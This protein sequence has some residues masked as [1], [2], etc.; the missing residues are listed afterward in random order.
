RC[1]VLEDKMLSY[2]E[3]GFFGKSGHEGE[4]V[5]D[6]GYGLVSYIA[7]EYGAQKIP[8]IAHN[9]KKAY[10][11]DM[12]PALKKATGKKGGQLYK[13]WK[14]TLTERYEK[15][16]RPIYQNEREGDLLDEGG[17][18][19]IAPSFSPDGRRIAYLSN[20]GS[21]YSIQ[22]VYIMD[23][24]GEN[25]KFLAGL[26]HSAPRFSPDG[27]K[28]IFSRK[29]MVDRYGSTVNDLYEYDLDS[30]KEKQLTEALRAAEPDYSPDGTNV[31]CVV[32]GDGSH[33][34]V[35][36][37]ADGENRRDVFDPG[38]GTQ[39]YHP[40]FSPDGESIMFG[41]FDGSTRDVAL[42]S[43]DGS[44][45][46]YLLKSPND[47]RDA[48]W[49][50]RGE[51]VIFASD[52]TGIYNIYE[53]DV[54]TGIVEKR[55]NVVGGAFMPDA[56]PD[57]DAI[58]YANYE[59]AGYSVYLIDDA[60]DDVETLD[61]HA[62]DQRATGEF[63]ECL[64]V[65]RATANGAHGV[66]LALG[67]SGA[68][69]GSTGF[70]AMPARAGGV[71]AMDAEADVATGLVTPL[72][73]EDYSRRY[74][75]FQFY[76]RFLIWDGNPRFGLFMAGFELLDKQSFFLGG[77]YGTTG[78]W[79]AVVGLEVRNLY[80]T[81]FLDFIA[82]HEVTTDEAVDTDPR[83]VTVGHKFLFDLSYTLWNADLGMRFEFWD[84]AS[85]RHQH[86]LGFWYTH[87]EYKI[88][89]GVDEFDEGGAPQG[90]QGAG[91][92]YYVGNQFHAQYVYRNI[93]TR[94]NADINPRSGR[95]IRLQYMLARDELFQEEDDFIYGLRPDRTQNDYNQYSLD[96]REYI[97][98]PWFGHALRLRLYGSWIDRTVN[99]FFW[100]YMG[101][102][103]GIRGYS[104]FSI[105]G[106]KG[107]LGS[108]TYR[109]PLWPRINKQFLWLYFRDIYVGVFGETANAWE[110]ESF[111]TKD[112]KYSAGY[113]A[114]M[115]LGSFY[116]FPTALSFIGAYAFQDVF[117][118][119][120]SFG[121][122]GFVIAQ[123]KGWSYY[124]LATFNF[125]L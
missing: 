124:F 12:D 55:S 34:L 19:T 111:Q 107:A 92:T 30:K 110:V 23:R 91:W 58:V 98:L 79:D 13:E 70:G 35:L 68:T 20:K 29:G 90:F 93:A 6:H 97:G 105:G 121:D 77:S 47:E 119:G 26:A 113:E 15:Q 16:T 73:S 42:I 45:F 94:V 18:M 11:L 74:S 103:D 108:L 39:L 53:V 116:V 83:S 86:D 69:R 81:L 76:P 104:Y 43:P 21:D 78:A 80:P 41:I 5:Y 33:K 51:R 102:M 25:K 109:F 96:W 22:S 82:I 65:R 88:N 122:F 115:S 2:D 17:Y 4:M 100:V 57:G 63:E 99:D 28:L 117:L 24:S 1:A 7:S 8:E 66:K 31:I 85:F 3:M 106:Q 114:R 64:A 9:L 75:P 71:A 60:Y 54:E 52:R 61:V 87:A 56:S 40:H 118:A 123:P 36:M 89:I 46:R 50:A 101:G 48:R 112:W 37:D 49:T 125:N 62:Y 44:N 59:A 72:E 10:Y 38:N 14:A 84:K 120:E 27:K 67:G 95:A 32:N